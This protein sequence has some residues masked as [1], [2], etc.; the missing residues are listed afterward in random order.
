MVPPDC[1]PLSVQPTVL[2]NTSE[3]NLGTSLSPTT[4]A[5]GAPELGEPRPPYCQISAVC[6]IG[7]RL[8]YKS[9]VWVLAA[10]VTDLAKRLQV[11][12]L[13]PFTF[14]CFQLAVLPTQTLCSWHRDANV[15]NPRVAPESCF[16]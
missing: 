16:F 10:A 11:Q 14:P 4:A 13:R 7:Q 15:L 6:P 1:A 9:V 5:D 12:R 2:L 8:R 3:R